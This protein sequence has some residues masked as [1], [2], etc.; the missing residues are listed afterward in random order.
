[1]AV[2]L[3]LYFDV[4]EMTVAECADR[5]AQA[6]GMAPASIE[7]HTTPPVIEVPNPA[8][9]ML[10]L[11]HQEVLNIFARVF[12]VNHWSVI[13]RAGLDYLTIDRGAFYNGP[14]VQDLPLT[15]SEKAAL[16]RAL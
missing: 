12:G 7:I 1:M 16:I 6:F 10:S 11:T 9:A 13:T 5:L 14:T 8:H 3:V 15:E 2:M 4:Q